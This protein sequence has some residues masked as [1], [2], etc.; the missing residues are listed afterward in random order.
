[1]FLFDSGG[2]V[3]SGCSMINNSATD[4]G[5]GLYA[6]RHQ[7]L[8]MAHCELEANTAGSRGGALYFRDA[9][10]STLISVS[11]THNRAGAHSLLI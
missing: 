2:V 1:M 10:R 6:F 3:L 9:A 8:R 5:G 7:D 11:F 4:H